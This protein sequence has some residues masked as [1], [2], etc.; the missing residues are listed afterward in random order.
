MIRVDRERQDP[1]SE[2][3]RPI[4]PPAS[5]FRAAKLATEKA[6]AEGRVHR[7]S[8]LYRHPDVRKALEALFY[9]KCAYCES[10]PG[11]SSSW[12]VEHYRPKGGVAE[13]PDHPG[14]YW[15]AYTWTNLYMACALCNQRRKDAPRWDDPRT[16]PAAG[17]AGQFPL[18]D[19][20]DRAM[21]PGDDLDWEH[22]LLLDPCDP[23]EDPEP[24]LTFDSRGRILPRRPDDRRALVTIRI[25][26]LNR[27][28]LRKN[29]MRV[30]I[31]VLKVLRIL[32]AA[33]DSDRKIVTSLESLLAEEY[34][35]DHALYAGLAR[36]VVRDPTA[37]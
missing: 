37:F 22:P 33:Q 4:R 34:L 13:R 7:A 24:H 6:L 32:A 31:K 15:L 20:G 3:G 21:S 5:W 9:G 10:Q 12:D 14:Y 8:G 23:S 19:E 26:H 16:L 1:G 2:K 36:A 18:E 29:R 30:Q 25:L 28:R 27:R 35:A 17:K 11:P